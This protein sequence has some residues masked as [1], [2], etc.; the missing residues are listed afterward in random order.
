MMPNAERYADV[1][2]PLDTP[3]LTFALPEPLARSVEAG[4]RV[5]VPL[6]K[7]KF[8]TGI[9]LR[10]HERR[11]D[12]KRIRPVAEVTD[13]APVVTPEQLRLW[14]WMADYYLCSPGVV[15]R[16]ALPAAL[17]PDGF[18]SDEALQSDYHA[19][20]IPYVKL[21]PRIACEADLH[22]ALDSLARARAR[23][24]A[25]MD[26]L[27]AARPEGMAEDDPAAFD[28][29]RLEAVPRSRI[30]VSGPVFKALVEREIFEL[31]WRE[32]PRDDEQACFARLP[33][34]SGAQ[35]RALEALRAGLDEKQVALLHGVTGSGKTEI[36]IHL[37][38][39][40]LGR[41]GNVLYL[42]PEIAL[43]AQLIERMSA[44]FG[45]AVVVYHSRLSDNRRAAVYR[46]LLDAPGG[47]LIMGVRSSVLL[48]TPALS[49]VVI[50]EEHE[51]SFKQ[52]D[53][54]PRYHARDTAV[55]L[56]SLYGA[57]TL[58]GSA[59]PSLE[60][61]LNACGGKYALVTLAERYS[62]V[63]LP[64]VIVSDTLRA[65]KRGEK[66]SHF[67]TALLE[68]IDEALAQGR[69]AMLFQ[70]RRG[71]SP[72][73]ECG[74]CG[75]TA[76]CPQCNVTLTYHKADGTLRCHYC[77]YQTPVPSLCP[78]CS[79]QDLRP[80]G[81]GTEKIEEE[82]QVIFPGAVI[83]RLDA[84]TA[85][86]ARSYG[87]IIASFEQG[88]TDILVGTQMITKGF[89][90]GRVSLV[91]I[92]NAD[93]LLNYPDFRA[94]E[95]AFQLMMQVGGR[96]GRRQE[97][98]TVV[99]QTTQSTHPVIEQ[100]CRGDYEAM[101]AAQLS[102]RRSFL[103][104]PYCRLIG[105]TFRHR[106][107][108]LVWQAAAAFGAECRT[109]FG[110]RLLGP[111]APPVDRVRGQFLVRFL[112]KIEKQRSAARAKALLREQI[113][114]LHARA[115]FRYVEVIPDVDPQ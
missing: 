15:M 1:I 97:Q 5:I 55:M 16:A 53:T 107:K 75:W 114:R 71:F 99:I 13:A 51:N 29:G 3:P 86:T 30:T 58:L 88:R 60:S 9:V 74:G 43:T 108:T 70:N 104:P 111:E 82:L 69:Q 76:G 66:R 11:P 57:K 10:V 42:L 33:Q 89:D 40:A 72:Y 80:M 17:K 67:N 44:Y 20:R 94:G 36:Y 77:G 34:L 95:R 32:A 46:G 31:C 22:A 2:L 18:S 103:Y 25:V 100:V 47:R 115:E 4:S 112:L 93:N 62:G 7:S 73:V 78:S 64:R 109:V 54:A 83:D 85:R 59:T 98:G 81:F 50:D 63:S 90:F 45:S 6:G 24:R 35:T 68:R 61:Y 8:Y 27:C 87:R 110:A 28:P 105:L 49:L 101:A 39:E 21:H 26:Y 23:H 84:D 38:A 65:A 92:L 102:E 41:G 79:A 106:D 52:S 37:I 113:E 14:L 56:A 96:A 19:P 48:P 12:F 91:G